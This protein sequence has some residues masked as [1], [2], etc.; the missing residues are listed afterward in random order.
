MIGGKQYLFYIFPR[1]IF[2]EASFFLRKRV[3]LTMTI[4]RNPITMVNKR[5]IWVQPS[6]HNGRHAIMLGADVVRCNQYG[7]LNAILDY[8]IYIYIFRFR[9]YPVT[10]VGRILDTKGGFMNFREA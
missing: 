9:S 2:G 1:R 10:D 7:A 6:T 8:I 5:H 4:V 3:F